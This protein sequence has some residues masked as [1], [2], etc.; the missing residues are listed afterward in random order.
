MMRKDDYSRR[1]E[2]VLKSR[3]GRGGGRG[4]LFGIGQKTESTEEVEGGD[5]RLG[6]GVG[7]L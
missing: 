7:T 2:E 3:A 6:S 4:G 1:G 5:F